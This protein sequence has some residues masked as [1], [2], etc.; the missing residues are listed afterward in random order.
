[1][2]KK[3]EVT[4]LPPIERINAS[5]E[6]GLSRED[7]LLRTDC[8]YV[9]VSEDS[10][11]RTAKQIIL[12]N[13]FTYFN[14]I[15]FVLAAALIAVGSFKNLSFLLIVA[16]NTAIGIIQEF[17]SKRALDKLKLLSEPKCQVV[18]D[19]KI[20]S[21]PSKSL[22]LDDIVCF[23]GGNQICAD[24]IVLTGEVF[25]NESLV[26]GE[27]DEIRKTPGDKLL[28]GS[29]IVSGTCRA[30]L[31]KVG[32]DSFVSKLTS[33]AKRFKKKER[34]GMMHSLTVLVKII[35][36]AVI[37]MGIA[38]FLRQRGI[39]GVDT[40]NAVERTTAA[41]VG[42]IPEGLYL[43]AN[44]RLAVSVVKLS[45]KKT[46][47]HDL[48]CIEALARVDTLCV[49]KTG[50]ITE[51]VM[52]FSG[53]IPLDCRKADANAVQ[54]LLCDFVG[55]MPDDNVTMQTL[56]LK[57]TSAPSKTAYRVYPFS[58][59]TKTSAVSFGNGENYILGAPEFILK[60]GYSR[61]QKLIEGYSEKGYRVLLFARADSIDS[62]AFSQIF[63]IALI[64]L[65]NAIRPDAASTFAY[66]TSQGVN[67]K[68][69]SGDNPNTVSAA[70]VA[71]KIPGAEKFTAL[72][73]DMSDEE[74]KKAAN[75]YTVFGR[76]TPEQKQ[77]L[78]R[79]LKKS[80]HTVAMTG[81]G[82]NDVLALKEADCSIAM[83]SGS[84]IACKVSDLV[85]LD[86]KFS[87]MPTVVTEGR[88]VINNIERSASL[89]LIKN[90]F[91]FVLALISIF[92]VFAYPL[93]PTQLSLISALTIGA[94]A[95][96]LALEKSEGRIKGKFLLNV[97]YRALPAATTNL[98]IIGGVLCFEKAFLMDPAVISTVCTLLISIV[99]FAMIYG[100]CRPMNKMRAA[101]FFGL[102]ACYIVCITAFPSF[103]Y[104]CPIGF[105]GTL[106][107]IVFSV[108]IPTMLFSLIK[109]LDK[110]ANLTGKIVKS[111][112]QKLKFE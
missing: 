97:I 59:V 82:V 57:F 42:I 2:A 104:L 64:L 31:D 88:Q 14:I 69:I 95:F 99:G 36:I 11:D 26:T 54:D 94:P 28:S 25:V 101:M 89:F 81:D 10:V 39:T 86:S 21:V 27:A 80:G 73:P 102:L 38:L 109:L 66:F 96:L 68:V 76:V 24:A 45:K 47:V 19:G 35:G 78:I 48:S 34:S 108:M 107:L 105:G 55:N 44:I 8:G 18:R 7:V 92:A 58:S 53:I 62:G 12:S 41:L 71:A 85:L 87:S 49:D 79:A 110:T 72:N 56:K 9:N 93:Q 61:Y 75:E 1:M 37:P 112:K 52:R 106:V 20:F 6:C 32:K 90:I 67:I 83:A 100:M 4:H 65:E 50:T 70:A 111:I 91:S 98:I 5:P 74:L 15:F 40:K 60:N 43:L 103:F 84:D 16:I 77:K 33:S 51:P 30:R 23:S 3:D 46:L 13:V 22:V 29:Y 63:P 17:N